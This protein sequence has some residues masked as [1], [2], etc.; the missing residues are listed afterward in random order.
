MDVD[1]ETA[2]EDGETW[3]AV[4]D[5]KIAGFLVVVVMADHLLLENVVV[6]PDFQGY[7]LGRRLLAIAEERADAHGLRKIKLFTNAV[8]VENQQLYERRGYVETD[9]RR[10]NRFDRVF[11]EKQL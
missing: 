5:G 4:V 8:M 6:H 1:Y 11:Y 9:R 3:V 10:D 2:I 7:G